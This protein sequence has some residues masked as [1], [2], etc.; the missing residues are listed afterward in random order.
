LDPGQ[1]VVQ[2]TAPGREPQ[3]YEVTLEEGIR[4]SLAVSAG[5]PVGGTTT[6]EPGGSLRGR[7]IAGIVVGGIGIAGLGVGAVTGIMALNKKSEVDALCPDPA[8]C[9]PEGVELAQS[10]KTLSIVSTI[11]L[12]VGILGVGAGAFLLLTGGDEGAKAGNARGGGRARAALGVR[13][14]FS[15]A[16]LPGGGMIGVR[17]SF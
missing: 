15:A 3:R 16:P 6:D 4:T 12:G 17:G 13:G 2:V 8:Q 1:H 9:T 10:G 11:G 14:S 5:T 7:T